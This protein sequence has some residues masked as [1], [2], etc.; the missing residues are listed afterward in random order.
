MSGDSSTRTQRAQQAWRYP[1]EYL[2][3]TKASGRVSRRRGHLTTAK[4]EDTRRKKAEQRQ[5]RLKGQ[6]ALGKSRTWHG[7]AEQ[8]LCVVGD[9]G[10]DK[11][12]GGQDP[13]GLECWS[14]YRGIYPED[15]GR[16]GGAV[17]LGV[18]PT[19]SPARGWFSFRP[20]VKA[21]APSRTQAQALSDW[22]FPSLGFNF[23]RRSF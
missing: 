22:A 20:R 13:E 3:L 6:T 8:A 12:S 21:E 7:S 18:P 11:V 16:P 10:C 14:K 1:G 17:L 5:S 19:V 9:M 15:N 23:P 2:T 4:W